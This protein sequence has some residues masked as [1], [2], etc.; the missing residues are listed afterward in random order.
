MKSDTSTQSHMTPEQFREMAQSAV[1]FVEQYWQGL[2]S[3][4]ERT[5][6]FSRVKPGEVR[7]TLPSVFDEHASREP[8][9]MVEEITRLIMPGITHWQHPSFFGFF[10]ANASGPAV[11]GELLAAGLGVQGMLWATS[12]ACTEL[13]THVLDA[14]G[15]AIGLPATFLS[16]SENGGGVIQGTASEAVLAALCAARWRVQKAWAIAT[17]HKS[18]SGGNSPTP[19]PS[20]GEGLFAAAPPHLCLYTSSQA[21]SSVV[22]AAM[23]AG[24]AVGPEDRTHVRIIDVDADCRMRVDSLEA[25][26]REDV[27]AGKVPCFVSATVGTTGSTAIDS[28]REIAA[29]IA[30]TSSLRHS[31]TP[32][33]LPWLHVDAA[34]AGAACICPEYQCWLDGIEHAD[35]FCF[36][37]H[38]WLLTNFDC[39]CFWTRD[40][41]SLIGSMSITPEYL[42][43]KASD[44][45]EVFDYRD[46]H[47]PLGRRFR[48]LKLWLTLRWYGLEGLRAYIRN[49]MQL[50]AEFEAMVRSDARFEVAAVRTMNLVCFRLKPREGET[51]A[52]TDARNKALLNAINQSG[53]AYLSH[54]ALP[55]WEERA[56]GSNEADVI[57]R[58]G[59]AFVLRMA[60]GGVFTQREH[61]RDAWK[62]MQK[63]AGEMK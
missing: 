12:P 45:G 60:I 27:A 47:V 54:T 1:G 44:A 28:I 20:H 30:R 11:I 55:V 14:L 35:S 59:S 43:N 41:A 29:A 49:H 13:E 2:Q 25:A 18:S 24:L 39:D 5:P 42:R 26:M 36:N 19:N 38:K 48:S 22:K 17:Q 9:A 63:L 34:H 53:R 4:P 57:G 61:V 21:H 16:T 52:A 3:D 31:V 33:P 58:R 7:S 23:I 15:A 56:E 32:L 6:V 8:R 62:L 50:A 40:R 46:W 51:L 10:P 37:P